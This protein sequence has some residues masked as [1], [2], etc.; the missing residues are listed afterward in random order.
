MRWRWRT[1][2]RSSRGSSWDGVKVGA[3]GG[4]NEE[5]E[6]EEEDMGAVMEGG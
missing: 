3:H 1:S 6:E 5:G 4:G 2:S